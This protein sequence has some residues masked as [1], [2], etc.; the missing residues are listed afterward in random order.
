M[1][2]KHDNNQPEEVRL[3]KFISH[4]SKYSRREAD[5]L[6][7]EGKVS[8]DG[9]IVSD[10]A[11]KVTENNK[12]MIDKK[13]IRED[14]DKMFTVIVYNKPKGELVTKND[15]QGRRI[16]YDSLGGKFQHFTPVGRLD[17]ASEGV[18]LLSDSVDVVNKLMHSTL[19]RVYKIKVNGYITPAIQDAMLHGLDLQ[20]ASTGAHDSSKI[21]AM[22]F[23]PFAAFKLD[24]NGEKYSK[25]KVAISEGKNRELRRFFAHFGLDVMDLKRIDFGGIELNNLPSGKTRYLDKKEYQD[26]RKFLK[27]ND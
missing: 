3:N 22:S 7:E 6:I 16:I 2:K 14:K 26:L 27:L 18:L 23:A 4:N 13:I 11:T 19:E 10:M 12:V 20:D 15:P 9:K 8:V 17:Y 5:R 1:K 21:T 24:S 25:L